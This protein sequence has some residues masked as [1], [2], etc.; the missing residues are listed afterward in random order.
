M[1]EQILEDADAFS[2]D[3]CKEQRME[4]KALRKRLEKVHKR[5]N[6]A[7]KFPLSE[8]ESSM[9]SATHQHTC[10]STCRL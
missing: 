2:S 1:G 6:I 10:T 7:C 3:C 4:I 8:F 5:L 9:F